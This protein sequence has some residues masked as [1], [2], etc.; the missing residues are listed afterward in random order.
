MSLTDKQQQVFDMRNGG[1]SWKDIADTIG[2]NMTSARNRY[3]SAVKKIGGV[4]TDERDPGIQAALDAVGTTLDPNLVW[5]KTNNPDG[6]SYSVQVKVGAKDSDKVDIKEWI[7][8]QLIDHQ[9]NQELPPRF[10]EQKGKL[11]VLDPSDVHI[12][13][14]SVKSETGYHYDSEVAEHRLVEGSRLLLD[15]AKSLG[16]SRVLFVIGNDISHIDTPKRTTTSGTFQDTDGSLFTIFRVASRAYKKIVN[17]CLDMELAIDVV[18]C[19]SNHDWITGFFIAQELA[20]WFREHPNFTATEYNISERHRKYYRFGNNLM[21]FTHADGAKEK[22]LP[23]IMLVE[24]R[25]H[26]AECPHRYAYLHHY[27]HRMRNALGVRSMEREKD[28]IAMTVSTQGAGAQEGDNMDIIYVRSPSPPDGWHDRNGYLNR[29]A[30][31]AF[32]HDF[33]DGRKHTLTEWF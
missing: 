12:G 29:Q 6:I 25:H 10:E 30:V 8:D 13:K 31:E 11:M 22:D 33:N 26:I 27:H 15:T 24:A 19:P 21:L 1:M 4:E 23:Q 32:I 3:D 28:H 7:R 5:L 2:I 14:M 16:V 20:A 17:M 18:F 9:S